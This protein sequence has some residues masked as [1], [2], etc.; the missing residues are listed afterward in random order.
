MLGPVFEAHYPG[1][2]WQCDE[3]FSGS[4][5]S[6]QGDMIQARSKGGYQ[7]EKC[8]ELNIKPCKFVGSSDEEMG[9]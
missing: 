1:V 7:H 8:P 5:A 9:F 3:W 2:C 6:G 4:S